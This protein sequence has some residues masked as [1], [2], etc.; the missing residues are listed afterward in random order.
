MKVSSKKSFFVVFL[1]LA[2][3]IIGSSYFLGRKLT[4][5]TQIN[6]VCGCRLDSVGKIDYSATQAF[7]EGENI[8]IPELAYVFDQPKILGVSTNQEKLVEI[9]L[10]EQRLK[11]WEGDKLFLETLVST[12]LP[13]TPTPTGEFRIWMKLRATRMEGGQGKYYYNLPNVPYV[14]FFGNNEVPDWKGYGLHGTYWHNDFGKVHSHGCVNLPT[15]V[16]KELYYWTTPTM[17]DGK[18]MMRSDE[19]SLGTK[20]VIHE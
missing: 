9:D 4:S 10:S 16:A 1:S 19:S 7:F 15:G 8:Q 2:L 6:Q 17:P 14:M 5:L 3:L 20:I 12:G 11:A 13:W 18:S